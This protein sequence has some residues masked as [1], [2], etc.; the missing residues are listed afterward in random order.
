MTIYI[1]DNETSEV[2]DEYTG[3]TN[4]ECEAWARETWGSNGFS[5]SYCKP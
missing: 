1:T 5:W 3:A 4:E 2:I